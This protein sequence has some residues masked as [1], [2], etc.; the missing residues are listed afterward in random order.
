M[1]AVGVATLRVAEMASYTISTLPPRTMTKSR[2]TFTPHPSTPAIRSLCHSA[3][4]GPWEPFTNEERKELL[5]DAFR[6]AAFCGVEIVAF[7][8]RPT[9]FDFIIDEPREIHLSRAE[10]MR[11][12]VAYTPD[13]QLDPLKVPLDAG[14]EAAWLRLA[15]RFGNLSNFIKQVKQVA[16]R[17]YHRNHGT[18]GALWSSRFERAFVQTGHVSRLLTAWMDHAALRA[19]E[20]NSLEDDRFSTFGRASARDSRAR[21]M[22]TCLFG[23]SDPSAS[24]REVARAYRHFVADETPRPGAKRS[25]AGSKPLLTRPE[26]LMTEVPHFRNG[27]AV[28]DEAFIQK[29]FE[30][31]RAHFGPDRSK[32]GHHV[33]GQS[34]PDIWT[35]RQKI[36]LRKL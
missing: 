32:A 35:I 9:S 31:N 27:L 3:F 13:L 6:C 4:S 22:I 26:L 33:T 15:S 23:P 34:D 10:M 11:R 29:L 20:I 28:G 30:L 5:E 36:D 1:G 18:N 21:A 8:I 12:L 14:D 19:E 7:S 25:K 2:S 17:R 16:A 24:W